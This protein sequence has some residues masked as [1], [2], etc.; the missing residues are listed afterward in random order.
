MR[1]CVACVG[2][3]RAWMLEFVQH[4]YINLYDIRGTGAELV[5]GTPMPILK[6]DR[7]VLEVH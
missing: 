5:S 4:I 3:W 1:G 2:V 6:V 7:D